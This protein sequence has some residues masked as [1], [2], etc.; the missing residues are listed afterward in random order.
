MDNSAHVLLNLRTI[1]TRARIVRLLRTA[2]LDFLVQ[3]IFFFIY[4][5]YAKTLLTLASKRKEINLMMLKPF[6]G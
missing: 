1:F 3:P 4:A 6:I 2:R 5:Y